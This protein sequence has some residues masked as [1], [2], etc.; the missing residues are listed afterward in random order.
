MLIDTENKIVDV[1]YSKIERTLTLKFSDGTVRRYSDVP[2]DVY[3][4]FRGQMT[5]GMI[6]ESLE[7]ALS[8]YKHV[9]SV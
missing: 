3:E 4:R 1:N 7:Q 6:N 8:G 9:Q 2:E 5:G